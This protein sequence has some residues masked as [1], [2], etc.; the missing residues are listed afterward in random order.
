MKFP[1]YKNTN[2]N[3][4]NSIMKNFGLKENYSTLNLMDKYLAKGYKNVC[5]MIFDGLGTYNLELNLDETSFLRKHFVDSISAVFPPTT[6]ASTTSMQTGLSPCETSYIGWTSYIKPL[7]KN[8]YIFLNKTAVEDEE[9]PTNYIKEYLPYKDISSLINEKTSNQSEIISPWGTIFAESLEEIENAVV[10]C[11]TR[12]KR[13][14]LY[15]YYAEPDHM[16][17][18]LGVDNDEVRTCVHA[19]DSMIERLS[20]KLK[21]TLIIVSADHGHINSNN[22]CIKDYPKLYSML[23]RDPSI[24][25]RTLSFFVKEDSLLEFREEYLKQ[26]GEVSILLSHQEVLDKHIFGFNPTK[27]FE[28]MIGDYIA[29]MTTPLSIHNTYGNVQFLKGVHAGL[30]KEEIEIPFIIVETEKSNS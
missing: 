13:Q 28:S 15:T 29:V 7:D 25:S 1:N 27:K 20:K 11:C 19:I 30:T 21:D 24:E 4:V 23:K 12:D 18:S 16:M 5:Y 26:F 14:Y 8:A 9:L 6:V 2:L 10:D 17:H 3:L 22:V